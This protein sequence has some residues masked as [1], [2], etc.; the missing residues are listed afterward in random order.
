MSDKP[1]SEMVE[2]DDCMSSDLDCEWRRYYDEDGYLEMILCGSCG[3]T[4]A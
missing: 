1:L 3:E 2:L 4:A